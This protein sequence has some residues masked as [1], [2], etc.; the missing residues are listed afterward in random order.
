M[1]KRTRVRSSDKSRAGVGSNRPHDLRFYVYVVN[2]KLRSAPRTFHVVCCHAADARA[3]VATRQPEIDKLR[4]TRGSRVNFI[5]VG[6]HSL[7]E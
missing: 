7:L 4:V 1:V 3:M 6:D 2:G 5:A